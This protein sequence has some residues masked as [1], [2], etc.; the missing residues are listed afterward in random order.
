M[1]NNYWFYLK[2]IFTN[3]VKAANGILEENSLKKI[4]LFS[5][6]IGSLLYIIIVVMGYQALGWGNFPYKEYYPHYFS[7]YWWEVF[8]VPIW[9]LVIALGFGI[10]CYFI[11]KLFR[12]TGT[13]WQVVA[14][15]LLASI[16]SLPI[17]VAVD[18]L[19]ILYDPEWIIR[20]AKYGENFVPYKGYENKI[21]W[22]IETSYAYI[23]QVWQG[24]ITII[25]LTIIHKIRWYKN[26]P[27]LVLGFVILFIFLLL[28]RD[29]VA[30]II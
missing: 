22:V 19:T 21:V 30:L 26:I 11:G 13:F 16:V 25:G 7:P 8:V 12:G 28:I 3:P 14:F 5:F 6:L 29:Y 4:A 27:G 18:I 9:G 23:A 1:T 10:P 15:V 20:F 2:N 17:M 24:V